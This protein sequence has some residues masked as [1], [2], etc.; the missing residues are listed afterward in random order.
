MVL[1]EIWAWYI[2]DLG[3]EWRRRRWGWLFDITMNY[4]RSCRYA[5]KGYESGFTLDEKHFRFIIE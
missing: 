5:W 3:Y 4:D 1:E 2:W